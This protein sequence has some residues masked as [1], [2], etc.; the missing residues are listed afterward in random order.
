MREFLDVEG[1]VWDA[2]VGKESWGTL[3]IV[4]SPRDG[5]EARKSILQ[6]ETSF[7]A[8]RELASME[9]EELRDRLAVAQP[10]T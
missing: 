8:E 6:A 2:V 10:W 1:R 3:V 4:L 7:D 9:E 5:G